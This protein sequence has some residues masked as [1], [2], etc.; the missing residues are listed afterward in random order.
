[1]RV[2]VPYRLVKTEILFYV[3]GVILA[4]KMWSCYRDGGGGGG[5]VITV[6]N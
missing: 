2:S 4:M 1:M 6:M 5:A 3:K